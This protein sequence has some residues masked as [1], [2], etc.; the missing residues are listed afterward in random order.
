ML[1]FA[2]LNA[3]L[4]RTSL[5]QMLELAGP[6][7]ESLHRRK[8]GTVFPVEVRTVRFQRGGRLYRL[9]LAGVE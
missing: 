6:Y 1:E 3:R 7:S 2:G 9:A 4:C 8:D 5:A